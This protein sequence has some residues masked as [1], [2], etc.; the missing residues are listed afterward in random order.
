[1]FLSRVEQICDEIKSQD[2]AR[3]PGE[4]RFLEREKCKINKIEI[5]TKLINDLEQ[6]LI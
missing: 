3:L 4:R 1:M 2:G 6:R 5:P